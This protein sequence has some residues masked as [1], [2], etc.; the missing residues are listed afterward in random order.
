MPPERVPPE[1]PAPVLASEGLEGPGMGCE[2]GRF[3]APDVIAG[4]AGIPSDFQEVMPIY[5]R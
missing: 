1:K 5:I 4:C 2:C 3:G